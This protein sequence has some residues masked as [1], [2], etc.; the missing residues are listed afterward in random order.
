MYWNKDLNDR[1][2]YIKVPSSNINSSL[3]FQKKKMPPDVE[4]HKF[5]NK[6]TVEINC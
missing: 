2:I 4:I 3:L 6:V 1:K 5:L